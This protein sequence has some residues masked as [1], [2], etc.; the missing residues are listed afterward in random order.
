MKDD[1]K[2]AIIKQFT[3][4]SRAKQAGL[5]ENDIILSLDD[6]PVEGA[7]DMRIF[8]L[9]KQKG[10]EIRVKVLRERFLLGR[11]KGSLKSFFSINKAVRQWQVKKKRR[12][13]E[14][15]LSSS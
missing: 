7:D 13:P 9:S 12:G 3:P 11:E 8:L 4:D 15:G 1:D 2:K 5:K 10:D 14:K 6:T